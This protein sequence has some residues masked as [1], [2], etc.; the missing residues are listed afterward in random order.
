MIRRILL[1]SVFGSLAWA[2]TA[3]GVTIVSGPATSINFGPQKVKG[4]TLTGAAQTGKFKFLSISLIKGGQTHSY[5]FSKNFSVHL[6]KTL[7]AGSISAKLGKYGKLALKFVATGKR[8]SSGP[9]KECTGKKSYTRKGRIS[10]SSGKLT[11]DHSFFGK[12]KIRHVKASALKQGKV[13]CKIS[14]SGGSGGGSTMAT[15]LSGGT[16][17]AFYVF[18]RGKHRALGSISVLSSLSNPLVYHSLT[19]S[20]P[21]SSFT[22]SSDA[23][24][25]T[26]KSFGSKL[27]GTG[28]YQ[29]SSYFAGG[30]SG[31]L[32]GNLLA[33][34]DSIGSRKIGGSASLTMPGFTPPVPHAS[35]TD[36][37]SGDAFNFQDTSTDGSGTITSW[38]W[39]FGDGGTSTARNPTHTYTAPGGYPVTLTITDANGNSSSTTMSVT[40]P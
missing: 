11:L 22:A 12:V 31:N 7:S 34:F 39:D 35:F 23:K 8:Q 19:L 24:S 13:K 33:H 4:Y 38:S 36:T 32:G 5:T 29:G 1:L 21:L 30:S 26:V 27:T 25:A 14:N 28:T 18:T 3:Q 17:N 2:G 37:N 40:A 9:G 10:K 20:A 16:S 6:N 15:S